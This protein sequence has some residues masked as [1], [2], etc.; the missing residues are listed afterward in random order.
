MPR[1]AQSIR[2]AVCGLLGHNQVLVFGRDRLS[3]RC[4]DCG[5]ETPGWTIGGPPVPDSRRR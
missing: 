3:L 5:R 1:I 2:Q 4:V